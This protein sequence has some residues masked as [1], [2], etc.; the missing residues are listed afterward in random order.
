MCFLHRFTLCDFRTAFGAL[1][2]SSSDSK[3]NLIQAGG[4]RREEGKEQS[5]KEQSRVE[6]SG[7]ECTEEN[8]T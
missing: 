8:V 1:L 2:F 6:E 5:V 3:L 7:T 4:V